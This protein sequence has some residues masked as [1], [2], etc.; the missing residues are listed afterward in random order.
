MHVYERLGDQSD[1]GLWKII[2]LYQE[3]EGRFYHDFSRYM[4][5]RAHG[6]KRVGFTRMLHRGLLL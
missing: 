3:S 1:E 5:G 6:G 2:R 4:Y